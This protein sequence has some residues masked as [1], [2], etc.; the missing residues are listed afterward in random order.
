[1]AS[2]STPVFARRTELL[3]KSLALLVKVVLLF[4]SRLRFFR[5]SIFSDV[6]SLSLSLSAQ[7][8]RLISL[9][10]TLLDAEIAINS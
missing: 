2:L 9:L 4:S 1:M 5:G 6:P 10:L 7:Q 3:R 8:R